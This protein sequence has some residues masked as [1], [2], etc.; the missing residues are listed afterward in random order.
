MMQ[1]KANNPKD[2]KTDGTN[3]TDEIISSVSNKDL[4]YIREHI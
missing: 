2:T 1:P 3:S 4:S